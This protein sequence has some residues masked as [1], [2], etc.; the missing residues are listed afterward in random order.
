[1][2][3]E[4]KSFDT[5][6]RED[7]Q[8]KEEYSLNKPHKVEYD[9]GDTVSY[10]TYYDYYA[11]FLYVPARLL[12]VL[13]S[14]TSPGQVTSASPKKQISRKVVDPSQTTIIRRSISQ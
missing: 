5:S 2:C 12:G 8:I 10:K 6:G 9:I 1:M 13:G 7:G 11:T 3:I 4:W 14:H